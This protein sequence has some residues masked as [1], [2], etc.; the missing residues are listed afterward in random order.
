ML[1]VKPG[2]EH[3][4]SYVDALKRGWSPRP[5]RPGHARQTLE[6]IERSPEAFL[7]G[8]DDPEGRIAIR[9]WD[10]SPAP[11]L[12]SIGRWMWDGE[13]CGGI[14]LRWMNGTAD[15]PPSW[16]GHIGYYVVPWKQRRRLR[17]L[18][19]G[20]DVAGGARSRAT[21]HR[22]GYYTGQRCIATRH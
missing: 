13:F 22:R 16:L 6:H 2:L 20:A 3:L 8:F 9:L 1:L 4:Q 18:G 21:A 14:M 17:D 12:P 10:G 15:L 5:D 19:A 7:A 11:P